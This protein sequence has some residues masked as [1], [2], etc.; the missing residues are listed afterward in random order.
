[1]ESLRGVLSVLTPFD[2]IARVR[3]MSERWKS[4]GISPQFH[5]RRHWVQ[6]FGAVK[7]NLP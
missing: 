2:V 3:A 6:L 1:M 7:G 4:F 5:R